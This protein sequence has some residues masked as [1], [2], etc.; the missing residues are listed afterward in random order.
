MRSLAVCYFVLSL[1]V[2]LLLFPSEGFSQANINESLETSFLYVNTLTG[3]DSNPGTQQLPLKTIGA[4]ATLAVKANHQNIG[5]RVIISPGVYRESVTMIRTGSDTSLPITFQAA[6]NGTVFVSGA[7]QYTGWQTDSKNSAIYLNS[8]PNQWGLCPPLSGG[9]RWSSPG[10]LQQD[11]VLRQEMI[12]VNGI[13][14][15]QVLTLG[16]MQPGTFYVNVQAAL[17]YVWPAAGT[18]MNSTDVEVGTL[19]SLFNLEGKSN[20][21]V[22]GLTFEYANSCRENFAVSVAG[23]ST[24]VLFDTDNLLWNN[25]TGFFVGDAGTS[26]FTV[27]NTVSSHNGQDGFASG[28]SLYGQ[29]T[30]ITSEYN[31]WRGAQGAYYAWD[32]AG[33]HFFAAHN[34]T[35]SQYVSAYNQSHGIHWDTDV[36]NIQA[37]NVISVGN[38][39]NGIFFEVVEGPDTVSNSYICNNNQTVNNESSFGGG[40]TLRNAEEITMTGSKLYNNGVSQINI[41][42]VAGGITTYNWQTGQTFTA[43]TE[44]FTHTNNVLEGLGSSQY[45]FHDSYLGGSDWTDFQ[46]TLDSNN[47]TWWNQS[48]SSAFSVPSAKPGTVDSFSGWQSL[49]GQD[50][51]SHWK[52]PAST[53]FNACDI[54]VTSPDFWVVANNASQT[55]ANGTA[56]FTVELIPLGAFTGSGKLTVDGVSEVTGLSAKLSSPSA[57][58]PGS[59]SLTVTSSGAAAGTYPITIIVNSGST[60]R[61]VTA[62]LIVP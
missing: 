25:A 45:V 34:D 27:Q 39:L 13:P 1:S 2:S 20:I 38:L 26:N 19:P 7:V 36:A 3:S 5:T 8:W 46:S 16:Q 10:P 6:Q 22:R 24:N 17:V 62:S 47:N 49:T 50:T 55:V 54:P 30:N 42:G 28:E 41:Q 21:V 58:I 29:Y 48:N 32:S 12:F 37:S 56:T 23:D 31:N 60:T 33:G 61:T 18:D 57:A 59:A 43:I 44:Q 15:T 52:T 51:N 11:I 40:L 14:L 53:A 9:G 35:V 4:A